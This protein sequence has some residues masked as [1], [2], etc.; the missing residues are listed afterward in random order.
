MALKNSLERRFGEVT[1]DVLGG[2]GNAYYKQGKN[3]LAMEEYGEAV[4]LDPN[5]QEYE[6]DF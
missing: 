1:C 3:D 4:R 5:N 6:E 2:Y